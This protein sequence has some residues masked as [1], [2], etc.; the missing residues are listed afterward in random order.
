ME[1]LRRTD[2]YVLTTKEIKTFFEELETEQFDE[3]LWRYKS[4]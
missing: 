3:K 2:G 1:F 4:N